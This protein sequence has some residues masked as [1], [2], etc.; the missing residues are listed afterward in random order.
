MKEITMTSIKGILVGH[1]EDHDA[2]TGCTAILALDG[3]AASYCSPGFAPGS[4]E[5]DLLR[6]EGLVQKIHGL[7]LAGG[8]AFGLA[9]ADGV[10]RYLA[11]KGVGHETGF[12][13]VP[14]VPAAVIFDYPA[15]RSQGSRPDESMGHEAARDASTDPVGSGPH[16]A[17][18][19]AASGKI[20]DP[21]LSSPSGIGSFG[22]EDTGIQVAALVVANPLGSIVDPENGRIVSGLRKA[23]G[24]LASRAEILEAIAGL[25]PEDVP[26]PRNTVLV[27]VGTNASL[28]KL[29][30]FR[31][32]R[33]ASAGIARAVYPAHLMYDGDTVFAL[34]TCSG[35]KADVSWLGAMAAE[36]VGKA[37][38]R[39]VPSA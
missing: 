32:A 38:L 36:V 28:P 29:E 25:S 34:S 8:S 24:G 15:N 7:C 16:G 11:E 18:Y 10:A 31:L 26:M 1:C 35:P 2:R 9:A 20:G 5:T 3:A 14:L 37:I 13:K 33:M 27:A 23:G 39:S 6:P 19:S 12:I 22:L 30:L 21:A 4:R 17:G